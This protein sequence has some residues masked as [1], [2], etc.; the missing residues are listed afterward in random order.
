MKKLIL[1]KFTIFMVLSFFLV[2]GCATPGPM[3]KSSS[4]KR[5]ESKK[6]V[7]SDKEALMKSENIE[8]P[9]NYDINY[10]R[11]VGL[12]A[13]TEQIEFTKNDLVQPTRLNEQAI[14]TLLENEISRTK[15]FTVFSRQ[16]GAIDRENA[17]QLL[18]GSEDNDLSIA[19]NQRIKNPE[20]VLSVT[21][22]VGYEKKSLH[23][24]N[25]ITF[26]VKVTSSIK[27][28]LTFEIKESFPPIFVKSDP[29]IYFESVSGK[30]LGGFNIKDP[31]QLLD[32]YLEPM[33]EAIALLVNRVGNYFP[34]GGR[35]TNYRNG[36]F[37][38]DR[39]IRHGFSTRQTVILFVDDDG[40]I[41]PIAS[42]EVTPASE[43]GAGRIMKWKNE[44]Y[45][46]KIKGK[47]DYGGK[48]YLK[49]EAV[50]AVSAG[51]PKNYE[52]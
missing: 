50:Y 3:T 34:C 17:F 35:V 24:H 39:G 8:L 10:F 11:K 49:T 12:A 22:I 29:K 48:G 46:A 41:T 5:N 20:S 52:Y 47:M 4:F 31:Q 21:A 42:G 36:R 51:M 2:V 45:A 32:A 28:P 14:N 25:K 40:I 37:A 9:I 7:S 6:L 44:L 1:S 33:S 43:K 15:R 38:I 16:T 13:Y 23:D 18:R 19:E 30:H 27:D 26:S